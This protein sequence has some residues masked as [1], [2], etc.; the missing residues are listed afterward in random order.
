MSKP[1]TAIGNKPTGVSTEKRPPTL[2]GITKVLCFLL[3]TLI[4]ALFLQQT[5]SKGSLRGCSRLGNVDDTETLILQ[6][7]GE[8]VQ[9]IFADVVASVKDCRVLLVVQE[10]CKAI[11]QGFNDG[12]CP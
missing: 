12:T 5:E 3:A 11:A 7:L 8:F 10:P 6:E 2:S 9:I 1:A 4:F